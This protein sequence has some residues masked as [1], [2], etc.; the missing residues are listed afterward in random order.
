MVS[1]IRG[2]KWEGG[3]KHP[4]DITISW[5]YYSLWSE[6]GKYF[7]NQVNKNVCLPTVEPYNK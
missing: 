2:G 7:I 1:H 6:F 4:W 3:A 5:K